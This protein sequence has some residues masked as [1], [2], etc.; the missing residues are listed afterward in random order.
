MQG[1]KTAGRQIQLKAA[2]LKAKLLSADIETK[3]SV[4]AA[5]CG[6]LFS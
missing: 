2:V 4:S 5:E 1:R 3:K 6:A